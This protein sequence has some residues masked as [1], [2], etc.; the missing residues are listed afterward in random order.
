M[1]SKKAVIVMTALAVLVTAGAADAMTN[2]EMAD[3]YGG[4]SLYYNPAPS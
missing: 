2:C 4:K 3:F 1:R